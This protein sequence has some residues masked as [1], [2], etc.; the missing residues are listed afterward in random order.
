MNNG[1]T[2]TFYWFVA[3]QYQTEA[4]RTFPQETLTFEHHFFY[5]KQIFSLLMSLASLDATSQPHSCAFVVQ[6]YTSTLGGADSD[7]YVAS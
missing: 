5:I 4:K 7:L 1:K 6:P 2:Q 3:F